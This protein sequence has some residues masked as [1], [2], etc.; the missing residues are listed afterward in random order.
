MGAGRLS[1]AKASG[2]VVVQPAAAAADNAVAPNRNC[3]RPIKKW[4]FMI[5]PLE[6]PCRRSSF[7]WKGVGP[8]PIMAGTWHQ[9]ASR[10]LGGL[11]C[12]FAGVVFIGA[13]L[14]QGRVEAKAG[15]NLNCGSPDKPS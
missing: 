4:V 10:G 15:G 3:L 11:S 6:Q 7:H 13:G 12:A 2:G 8:S 14:K 1:V 5:Q 9:I